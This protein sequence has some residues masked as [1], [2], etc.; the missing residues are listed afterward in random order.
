MR[1]KQKILFAVLLI[2][3]L[4]WIESSVSIRMTEK[5]FM[6]DLQNVNDA[7]YNFLIATKQNDE[8]IAGE[9]YSILIDTYKQYEKKYRTYRPY[10]IRNDKKFVQDTQNVR[11]I[12]VGAK[13]SI[14][15]SGSYETIRTDL[16]P[17]RALWRE[18]LKRNNFPPLDGLFLDLAGVVG[19]MIDASQKKDS[20][21]VVRRY[22]RA[23]EIMKSIEK[24]DSS[25]D[26]ATFRKTLDLVFWL[27][28]QEKLEELGKSYPLLLNDFQKI[29][30]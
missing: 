30:P 8:A 16:E 5:R 28:K 6:V 29:S 22:Q 7:Y 15:S 20:A 26:I 10:S 17:V 14:S 23:D 13:D 3:V 25:D 19:F 12:F 4:L 24:L 21:E 2:P 18:L 1:K 11:E 9:A 27:A